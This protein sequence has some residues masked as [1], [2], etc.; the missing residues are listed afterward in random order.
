MTNKRIEAR[1]AKAAADANERYQRIFASAARTNDDKL[2][3]WGTLREVNEWFDVVR[4]QMGLTPNDTIP[5]SPLC[6]EMRTGRSVSINI[7]K[8]DLP[9]RARLFAAIATI[10]T[11]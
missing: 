9:A 10:L 11:N 2:L 8:L 6:A 3:K 1:A 4:N 5:L 7:E